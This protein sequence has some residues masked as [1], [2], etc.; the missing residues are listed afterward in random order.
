MSD[1]A[2]RVIAVVVGA[3]TVIS[4]LWILSRWF[5]KK[6]LEFLSSVRAATRADPESSCTH[7]HWE[8]RGSNTIGYGQCLDCNRE[9]NLADL[10]DSLR[11]R[12]VSSIEKDRK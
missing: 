1:D 4:L 12:M 2:L 7:E 10:F 11:N 8:V 3:S 9:V 5:N 6:D